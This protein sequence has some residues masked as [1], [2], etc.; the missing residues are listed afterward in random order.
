MLSQFSKTYCQKNMT[1]LSDTFSLRWQL[2]MAW[3]NFDSTPTQ[4]LVILKIL[5]PAYVISSAS[6]RKR[7]A[8][9]ILLAIFHL[10]RLP[11]GD[12][13]QPKQKKLPR[14]CLSQKSTQPWP[15]QKRHQKSG[16][17]T[18]QRTSFMPFPTMY[19]QSL[20]SEQRTTRAPR[21]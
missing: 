11:V 16:S 18:C 6:L 14:H 9:T 2:G 5:R 13:K 10:R 7:F 3:L 12:G 8:V 15:N 17:T 1:A 19:H 4:H 21:M 20:P